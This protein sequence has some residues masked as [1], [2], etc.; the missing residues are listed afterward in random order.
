[1][2]PFKKDPN[3]L[4]K[5]EIISKVKVIE[6]KLGHYE[7]AMVSMG[8][9]LKRNNLRIEDIANEQIRAYDHLLFKIMKL[10]DDTPQRKELRKL[11]DDCDLDLSVEEA[12]KF[13]I[14]YEKTKYEI[15]SQPH[16]KKKKTKKVASKL[17]LSLKKTPSD[18]ISEKK[19]E[20]LNC[21]V[22]KE[23]LEEGEYYLTE[24]NQPICLKHLNDKGVDF[25]G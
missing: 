8:D 23:S 18:E 10:E 4:S 2:F 11:I 12:E 13:L 21:E 24:S 14:E 22:C 9:D 5:Q 20:P 17:G 3:N 1:M 16:K 19:R 15:K 25:Y 7:T 6:E